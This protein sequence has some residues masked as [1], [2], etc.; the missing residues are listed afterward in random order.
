MRLRDVIIELLSG[1]DD[2]A[3]RMDVANTITF[4]ANVYRSGRAEEAE[5]LNDL[6][7]IAI[8]V[9]ALKEPN[10]STDELRD[11]AYE[12]AD[13]MMRSIKSESLFLRLSRR[14]ATT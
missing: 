5:I 6:R 13:K 2:P 11:K 1:I 10:L 3:I 4:L 9:L 14:Y 8:T 7:E 12:I